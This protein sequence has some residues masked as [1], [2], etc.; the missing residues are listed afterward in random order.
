MDTQKEYEQVLQLVKQKRKKEASMKFELDSLNGEYHELCRDKEILQSKLLHLQEV[1]LHT[2]IILS[3]P[4]HSPSITSFL[5]RKR[6]RG[7]LRLKTLQERLLR[8][9]NK[10]NKLRNPAMK[11]CK[12]IRK[13]RDS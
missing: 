4:F 9:K 13:R 6:R 8:L 3:C 5:Y 10:G 11:S 1:T 7:Y 2:F 12:H